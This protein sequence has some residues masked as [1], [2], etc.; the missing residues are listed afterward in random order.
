MS[1]PLRAA[2]VHLPPSAR[3]AAIEDALVRGDRAEA[4]A[5]VDPIRDAPCAACANRAMRERADAALRP[6]DTRRL[7]FDLIDGTPD[8]LRALADEREA[9]DRRDA[10]PADEDPSPLGRRL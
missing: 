7:V 8:E 6:D 1:D 3:L 4:L 2:R 9:A 10:A 5:L